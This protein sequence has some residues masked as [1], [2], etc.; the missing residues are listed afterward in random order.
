M[1]AC[2]KC[3]NFVWFCSQS[4]QPPEPPN[5][6]H[7]SCFVEDLITNPIEGTRK[8]EKVRI[9]SYSDLNNNLDCSFYR[10]HGDAR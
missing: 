1:L 2:N 9:K 4:E 10:G 3:A 8:K 6:T 5:C 7:E